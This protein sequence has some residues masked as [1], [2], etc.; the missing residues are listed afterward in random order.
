MNTHN[1]SMN[2]DRVKQKGTG[3]NM[4]DK[5]TI[6]RLQMYR[7]GKPKRNKAGKIIQAAI[8]QRTLASGTQARVEP[9][10]KWFGNTRVVTQSALQMFQEEMDKV[11][12]DPY[13]VVMK[14]TKQPIT[15]LQPVSVRKNMQA[16]HI[17]DV[18]PFGKCFGKK[19]TRKRPTLGFASME[20]MM[21]QVENANSKYDESK[22]S[23]ILRD[24]E[25][26]REQELEVVFKAGTSKR[27]WNE[28][29]KVIDSSDVILEILDA[30]DPIGTRCP[31]VENYLK[32][33]KPHKHLIIVVNKVDLVPAWVTQK[34]V[35]IL[36]QEYPAM[37]F[38]AHLTKPF[39]KGALINLLRQ[40][41]NLHLDKRQISVGLIGY[42]NVGK[43][44]IIN[45]LKSK[46]VCK[47]AP[48]A[49]ETKVWQYVTL[50]RKIYLVDCPGIVY[51]TGATRED[52][53]LKGVVRIENVR[54][55]EDYIGGMLARVRTDY[56]KKAY[57]VRDW[58][59]PEDFLEQVARRY[60]KL[61][62]GGEPDLPTVAKMILNDFQRGKIPYFVRPPEAP[63][64]EV[65]V[66]APKT[67]VVQDYNAIRINPHFNPED[68]R[69]LDKVPEG[70]D[71]IKDDEADV[72][73]EE[74][75]EKDNEDN[76]DRD[77][78]DNSADS[79]AV[80]EGANV[81]G[82]L[83]VDRDAD[84]DPAQGLKKRNDKQKSKSVSFLPLEKAASVD[85]DKDE[86]DEEVDDKNTN[87]TSVKGQKKRRRRG[88]GTQK[89]APHAFLDPCTLK[90]QRLKQKMK[91]IEASARR[92]ASKLQKRTASD[93]KS[94]FRRKATPAS[95]LPRKVTSLAAVGLESEKY[96]DRASAVTG[97][98]PCVVRDLSVS[99]AVQDMPT[100][101]D[102][103][104]EAVSA[105]VSPV[106]TSSRTSKKWEVS[107]LQD[108]PASGKKGRHTGSVAV[109]EVINSPHVTTV[110]MTPLP[111]VAKPSLPHPS[112]GQSQ[113]S[114]DRKRR[115]AEE[116]EDDEAPKLSSKLRR[117]M[118]REARQKKIGVHFYE[119]ANVKN[120]NRQ[121]KQ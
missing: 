105:D 16:Q 64:E 94:K 56:V 87:D 97:E 24:N 102:R 81:D 100:A 57:N 73:E 61:L 4:R 49:G 8:F 19:A 80:P 99:G 65:V 53:V 78:A 93:G 75:A 41:K 85:S 38:N 88:P 91:A 77:N 7:G 5:A 31:Q 110:E 117:R 25:G 44:S 116:I 42:P 6:K 83:E 59:S 82:K 63:L 66:P 40:F 84:V 17:L 95:L 72:E 108:K 18:M 22:D 27:I 96:V 54:D 14:P 35:A 58:T 55:P 67:T 39:G 107:S 47:V 12:R 92:N 68:N 121:K 60:G 71:L 101:S 106:P 2:P 45:A 36:S 43:S 104:T 28:L 52:C 34:W 50:M 30:R 109:Y 79:V 48:L 118:E 119:S 74:E 51:P 46:K 29:Y 10:R 70:A 114:K 111:A 15:L 76:S 26:V 1:H 98:T 13:K 37:A 86:D 32:K 90:L 33:E 9:N 21:E 103:R 113:R 11:K 120:R 69:P 3:Y 23:N 62:K 20:E 112:G 115:R 89:L